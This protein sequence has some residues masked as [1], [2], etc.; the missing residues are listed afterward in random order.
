M[1]ED[2]P[3]KLRS[4][5]TRSHLWDDSGMIRL[6]PRWGPLKEIAKRAENGTG[7]YALGYPVSIRYPDGFSHIVYIG[8]SEVLRDRLSRHSAEPHNSVLVLC[9][10]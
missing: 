3:R 7:V 2:I 1:M 10:S 5:L 9:H 4:F 6:T 8:S